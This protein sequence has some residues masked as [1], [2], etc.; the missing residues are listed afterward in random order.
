M[1]SIVKPVLRF[2]ICIAAVVALVVVYSYVAHVHVTTVALTFLI[3]VLVVSAAWSLRYAVF[4]CVISTLAYNYFFLPPVGHFSIAHSDD[5]VAL[6]AF[7][8][9]GITAS[10]LSER[11]RR[12]ALNANR[13]RA[14][15]VAAQQRFADLVNSVEGI[16]WEADARTFAFSFVSEQAERT[17][18]YPVEQW[19]L[20]PAFWKDHLH[21]EDRDWAVR[22]CQEATAEKRSHDFQYRMIGS[23]GRVVWLRDVVTVAVEDDR[24]TRLRGVMIDVTRR[25][26]DEEALRAQANLLSLMP[27]VPS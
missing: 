13:R 24:P 26:R 12:E 2:A 6:F 8:I 16:V 23:D 27:S 7:L 4:Q 14:E 15:A 9:T 10:Q 19:L 25:K 22:F 11:A 1:R 18:G 5:W 3:T 17:L 21:P 20:K